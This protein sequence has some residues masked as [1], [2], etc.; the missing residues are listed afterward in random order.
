[1]KDRGESPVSYR[2]GNALAE[3]IS[4][5]KFCECSSKTREG[6]KVVFDEAIRAALFGKRK[7]K[8]QNNSFCSLL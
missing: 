4:A 3:K 1:M 7:K 6:L 5:V 2:E 8:Q